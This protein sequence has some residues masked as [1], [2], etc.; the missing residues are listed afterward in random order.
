M[1]TL[2]PLDSPFHRLR[3]LRTRLLRLHK[4]LLDSERIVYEQSNGRI[5]SKG[6]FFQLVIGDG[7]FS[8]LRTYSQFIVQIDEALSDKETM[9]LDQA[10]ALLSE[11]PKLISANEN[12][13]Q[14]EQRYF[15]AIQ[16]DPAIAYMHAELSNF[17]S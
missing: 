17:L 1:A 16:R 3:E 14:Q 6:E 11:A 2:Q 4:A 15:E 9:T 7:W 13:T 5:K 8:W 12:G 10:N